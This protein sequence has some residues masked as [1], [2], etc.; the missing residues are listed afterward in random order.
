MT[1]TGEAKTV[2]DLM[3]PLREYAVVGDTA[4]VSDAIKVLTEAQQRLGANRQPPRAVLVTNQQ[5][6]VIGQLEFIDFLKALEP[7]YNLLGDLGRLSRAGVS[8]EIIGTILEHVRFWQ[9]DL[10]D[11]CRRVRGIKVTDVMHPIMQSIDAE[12]LLSDAVHKIVMWQTMR[13]LVTAGGKVVGVLRLADLFH[14]I[15]KYLSEDD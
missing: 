15:A 9:G 4:T 10:N 5:Q 14:E 3:I 2:R 7:K 11:V 8:D 12:T 1:P 6:D 13:A